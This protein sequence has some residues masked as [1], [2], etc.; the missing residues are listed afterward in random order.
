MPAKTPLPLGPRARFPSANMVLVLMFPV[1]E[2]PAVGA[3]DRSLAVVVPAVGGSIG[4]A[5]TTVVA[6]RQIAS[7]DTPKRIAERFIIDLLDVVTN[8][9]LVRNK[10]EKRRCRWLAFMQ[11]IPFQELGR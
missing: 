7:M 11:N 2:P 8:E 4:V 9:N 3:K 1:V 5:C 10:R 6:D